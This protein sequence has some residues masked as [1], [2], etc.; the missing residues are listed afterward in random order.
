MLTSIFSSKPELI[1]MDV[2]SLTKLVKARE[3]F[4]V[5]PELVIKRSIENNEYR[6]RKIY[7]M[8][9]EAHDSKR[10]IHGR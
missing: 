6:L 7:D 10:K 2:D 1:L 5:Y 8:L 3:E 4:A 9:Q